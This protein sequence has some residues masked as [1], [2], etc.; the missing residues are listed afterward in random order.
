MNRSLRTFLISATVAVGAVVA[1]PTVAS[2]DPVA[3]AEAEANVSVMSSPAANTRIAPGQVFSGT[4]D[5]AANPGDAVTLVAMP[6]LSGGSSVCRD[7]V[8]IGAGEVGPGR[9]LEITATGTVP[10]GLTIVNF[11]HDRFSGGNLYIV[12]NPF[13]L[14]SPANG[15]GLPVNK[16]VVTGVGSPGA[17]VDARTAD[18]SPVGSAVV[19]QDG[20]W[21]VTLGDVA[22]GPAT[23]SF[24]Q[25]AKSFDAEFTIVSA[26]EGSPLID[27][28]TGG[29]LAASALL[30]VFGVPALR[31]RLLSA[32]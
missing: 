4:A 29:A 18:G 14:R 19:G 2:A 31:R 16:A 30:L 21:S 25:G 12:D 23:I 9:A 10:D 7:G 1:V 20:T 15:E 17:Q 8:Q 5:A 27:P 13:E 24:T 11:C 28:V 26:N 3:E 6:L 22:Q 32:I